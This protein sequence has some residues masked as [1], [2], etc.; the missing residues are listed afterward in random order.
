M[1]KR[2]I[3]NAV[4]FSLIDKEGKNPLV[5]SVAERFSFSTSPIQV[6]PLQIVYNCSYKHSPYTNINADT[7]KHLEITVKAYSYTVGGRKE[8]VKEFN[9]IDRLFS[10]NDDYGYVRD[11][12]LTI[13][14]HFY[15]WTGKD[16]MELSRLLF[17]VFADLLEDKKIKKKVDR[18][19]GN[20]LDGSD[21][22]SALI[23]I[24]K[25]DKKKYKSVTTGNGADM[26][27]FSR[28]MAL[29]APLLL[30]VREDPVTQEVYIENDEE[31]PLWMFIFK[32]VL[33]LAYRLE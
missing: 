14:I 24:A 7:A 28:A 22:E 10:T 30:A 29:Y 15:K 33:D 11:S 31:I 17:G 6:D 13:A 8:V 32:Q 5:I 9:G 1:S 2:T 16:D 25:V 20:L 3:G 27:M 23:Y 18:E 19:I 4:Q 26:R 12:G 21:I